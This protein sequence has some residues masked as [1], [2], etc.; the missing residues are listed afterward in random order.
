MGD[1]VSYETP[2]MSMDEFNIGLLEKDQIHGLMIRS[3][4]NGY[5]TIGIQINDTEVLKVDSAA[6]DDAVKKMQYWAE[7][8]SSIQE[9]Y[10]ERQPHLD[11]F[12]GE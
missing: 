4:E 10:K 3:D 6:E 9:M 1:R 8:V 12:G 7:R 5:Y 2:I 11:K